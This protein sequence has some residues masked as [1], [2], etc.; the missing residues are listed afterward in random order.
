MK[1]LVLVAVVAFLSCLAVNASAV[2]IVISN[3]Y[4]GWYDEFGDHSLSNPNYFA[5][6]NI[7]RYINNFFVFD[8]SGV[9]GDL[10]SATFNVYSYDVSVS[11][12]YTLYQTSLSP[13]IQ[14]DCT[15]CTAVFNDL[16]AGA[17]LGSIVVGP[18]D[19]YT[20]LSIVLNSTA[21]AWLQ[22]NE[23][24]QVVLGGGF[25]QPSSGNNYIFGYSDFN[26]ANN[27]TVDAVPE[28]GTLLLLGSGLSA[29]VLRRRRKA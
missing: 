29:L 26:A 28:P 25:P 16:V 23:G 8:L 24:G 9:A 7:N 1:R 3:S 10:G 2:P 5:G 19:S 4:S 22:A 13:S 20:T 6:Y 27:L 12:T 11:G 21:L 18:G 15:G 17:P 14:N